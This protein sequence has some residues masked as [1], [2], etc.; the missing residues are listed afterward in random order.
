MTTTELHYTTYIKS[1]PERVW[2][3]IT[4]P[5]FTRQYWGN[6]NISDWKTGSRWDHRT[7]AGEIRVSGIVRVHEPPR[8]LVLSWAGPGDHDDQS[9]HS[10]VTFEITVIKDMVC[11][12]VTHERLVAGSPMATGVSGGWPRVLSSLKSYLETGTALDTWAGFE[13]GC[14]HP[15]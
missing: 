15:A 13:H 4:T 8:R 5:E 12:H 6:A 11:L 3:A 10:Q 9:K 2:A 7:D 14:G 1:T